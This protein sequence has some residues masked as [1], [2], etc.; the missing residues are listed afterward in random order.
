MKLKKALRILAIIGLITLL[1]LIFIP[2]WWVSRATEARI[3][4]SVEEIP[5]NRVGLLLGSSKYMADGQLNLFYL[6][7]NEAAIE[8]YEAGKIEFILASG[9]NGREGYDEPSTIKDDL[10][11]AGIPSEKIYLDYAGFRTL[12]SVVRAKEIFGQESLTIISQPFHNERAIYIAQKNGMEAV[13]YNA[14]DVGGN[15]GTRVLIRENL[16]RTKMFFDLIFGAEP[17]YLGEKIEIE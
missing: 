4:D 15:E 9:D 12:D 8:L 14:Q 7:R 17:K 1:G 6:Y 2:D 3:Y 10:M 5:E 11:A 13:G 16:A